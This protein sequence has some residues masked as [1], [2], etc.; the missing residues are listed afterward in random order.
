MA[1]A[2]RRKSTPVFARLQAQQFASRLV[3]NAGTARYHDPS[4]GYQIIGFEQAREV[5]DAEIAISG[6]RMQ[7]YGRELANGIIDINQ[8]RDFMAAEIKL[9]HFI[10]YAAGKGGFQHLTEADY[11]KIQKEVR[12]Q[13]KYLER[14]ARF[15]DAAPERAQ[16]PGFL[17]RVQMYAEAGRDTYEEAKR[18]AHVAAGYKWERNIL[19]A[20]ESCSGCLAEWRKGWQAI[21]TITRIGGRICLSRCRCTLEYRKTKPRHIGAKARRVLLPAA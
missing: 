17:A 13:Y 15:L 16:R 19:H 6:R 3:W 10:N 21:G 20:R 4:R 2:A 14:F 5:V 11:K 18:A 8:W 12:R 9:N 1:L 7:Q